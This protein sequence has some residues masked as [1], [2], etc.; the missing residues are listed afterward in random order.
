MLYKSCMPETLKSMSQNVWSEKKLFSYNINGL[1]RYFVNIISV[2][3]APS[4]VD[5]C[6]FGTDPDPR[7]RT[8]ESRIRN[9]ILLFSLVAF[10]M[11]TKNKFFRIYFVFYSLK[12]R[13]HQ[14]SKILKSHEGSHKTV[15][16]KVFRTFF[17]CD[18]EDPDPASDPDPYK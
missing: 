1:C 14:S 8:T 16:F 10:K 9:W 13:L 17:A 18:G 11:T 12:V 4:V 2:C 7:I 6:H 3:N 5:P 15:E